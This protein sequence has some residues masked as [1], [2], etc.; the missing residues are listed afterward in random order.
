MK[1]KKAGFVVKIDLEKAHDRLE[2]SF[3]K[4][5]LSLFQFPSSAIDLIMSCICSA[6]MA[7]LV[8]GE[9]SNFFYPSRGIRQGDP[10][11]PPYIFILYT[12]FLS[13]N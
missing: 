1:G 5:T 2:W 10:L 6:K 13:P 12:K 8:N 9:P 11:S 3:I 4:D 7:I